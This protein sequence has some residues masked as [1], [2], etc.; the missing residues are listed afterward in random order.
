MKH[1]HYIL[2]FTLILFTGCTNKQ[3]NKSEATGEPLKIKYAEGF[4]IG[5]ADSYTCVTVFNPWKK[6]EIYARYYLVKD[7]KTS[8]PQDGKKIQIPLKS[9]VAN[10]AT[11]F[12]FLQM[13]GELDK[14]TG[15]CSAA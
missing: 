13:L 5:K 2:L 4:S 10:S 15:V 7:T 6:G 12:E 1:L 3:K 11:Y 9:L 14:V 8:V